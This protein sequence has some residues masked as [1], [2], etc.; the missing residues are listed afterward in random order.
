MCFSSTNRQLNELFFMQ[1][2]V[3]LPV[4]IELQHYKKAI[5]KLLTVNKIN[6]ITISIR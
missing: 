3:R 2:I 6:G 1:V 4:T 5:M